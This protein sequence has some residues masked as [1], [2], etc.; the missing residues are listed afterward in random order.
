MGR[1][2]TSTCCHTGRKDAA[3]RYR[4]TMTGSSVPPG[5]HPQPTDPADPAGPSDRAPGQLRLAAGLWIALGVATVLGALAFYGQNPSLEPVAVLLVIGFGVLFVV[6]AVVMRRG[7]SAARIWLTV[8]G[9]AYCVVLWPALLVIPAV[10]LQFRP[11]SGAWLAA[12]R[13]PGGPDRTS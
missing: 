3:A 4:P 5:A 10:V 9:G 12:R 8:L 11:T 2:S 6:L 7:S 1:A 13:H